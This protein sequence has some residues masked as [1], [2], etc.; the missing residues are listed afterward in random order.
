MGQLRDMW[1]WKP[2]SKG[3]RVGD[4]WNWEPH[5]EEVDRT[6][7]I[8]AANDYFENIAK[9]VISVKPSIV[10]PLVAMLF[11]LISLGIIGVVMGR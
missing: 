9:Q 11:I 1:T 8:L 10:A 7:G 3:I 5:P 6:P 4:N 2:V